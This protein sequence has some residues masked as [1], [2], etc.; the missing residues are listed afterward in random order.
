MSEMY[1]NVNQVTKAEADEQAAWVNLNQIDGGVQKGPY[2]EVKPD[3]TSGVG[4]WLIDTQNTTGISCWMI[5]DRR[6]SHGY[7]DEQAIE[8]CRDEWEPKES[9]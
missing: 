3:A 5:K 8:M 2:N 1:T 7:S 9:A 4:P 6:E